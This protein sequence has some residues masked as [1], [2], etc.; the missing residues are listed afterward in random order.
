VEDEVIFEPKEARRSYGLLDAGF[1]KM[2]VIV[3]WS[4]VSYLR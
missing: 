3:A 2:E 4:L 1:C